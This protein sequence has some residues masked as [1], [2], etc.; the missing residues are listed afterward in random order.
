M[1]SVSFIR[2]KKCRLVISSE[3]RD[4][5]ASLERHV[6]VSLLV[7]VLEDYAPHGTLNLTLLLL[8]VADALFLCG[9]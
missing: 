9:N 2:A 4:Q 7:V 5:L 6:L 1:I 8:R 3:L